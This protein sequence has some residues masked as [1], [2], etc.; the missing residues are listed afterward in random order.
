LPWA[1]CGRR[2]NVFLPRVAHDKELFDVNFFMA[3]GKMIFIVIENKFWSSKLIQIKN[4]NYK[5]S[6]LL[7]MGNFY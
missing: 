4:F 5:V 3:Y 2:Q 7:K 1:F 6:L